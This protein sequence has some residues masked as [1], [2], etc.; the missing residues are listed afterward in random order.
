[1]IFPSFY[2]ETTKKQKPT[3]QKFEVANSAKISHNT[4]WT[5]GDSRINQGGNQILKEGSDLPIDLKAAQEKKAGQE[6]KISLKCNIHQW[7]TGYV[8]AFDHPYAAISK[9]DGSFELTVP[10]GSPLELVAWQE[11]YEFVLPEGK[12][13]R[14]GQKLDALKSGETKTVDFKIGQ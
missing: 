10:A 5:P 3:G 1:V 2:D 4:N 8:W 12:G 7:M 9:P 14:N 13:D 11:K 6:D